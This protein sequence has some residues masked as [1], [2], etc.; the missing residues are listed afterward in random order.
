MY[1]SDA[2]HDFSLKVRLYIR[3]QKMNPVMMLLIHT[4]LYVD[5]FDISEKSKDGRDIPTSKNYNG[6]KPG[7]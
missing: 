7:N 1:E 4:T 2:K 6:K 5:N 3:S